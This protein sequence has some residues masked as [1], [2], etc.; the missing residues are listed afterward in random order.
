[1]DSEPPGWVNTAE[2]FSP[3]VYLYFSSEFLNAE[4]T[5]RDA[6]FLERA[7]EP[8]AGGRLLDIGCGTGRLANLLA[9]RGYLVTGVDISAPFLQIAEGDATC[10]NL[11][12]EY[13]QQDM[14]TMEWQEEF[15]GAFCYFTTFGYFS[16]AENADVLRRVTRALKPGGS[17]LVEM[18]NR[19][20]ILRA[21][22]GHR[23]TERDGNFQIDHSHYDPL[24]GRLQT[25][26]T[27]VFEGR[28][29]RGSF[30]VRLFTACE[31]IYWLEASGLEYAAL[32][33]E[34]GAPYSMQG[35]RMSVVGRRPL[36][37]ACT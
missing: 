21:P 33:G 1:M 22:S 14:R 30:S 20:A 28:T 2:I 17:F 27:I 29:H 37:G 9:S 15:D 26:R 34:T 6:D 4:R 18:I 19:D 35:I 25:T 8:P 3:D 23:V 36:C 11:A 24:T 5:R 32:Y 16:D 12:V 7:L 31:L 13:R 10:L